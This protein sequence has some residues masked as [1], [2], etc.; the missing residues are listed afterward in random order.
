MGSTGNHHR[1]NGRRRHRPLLEILDDRCLLS[2]SAGTGLADHFAAHAIVGRQAT[3]RHAHDRAQERAKAGHKMGHHGAKLRELERPVGT[4]ETGAATAYDPIIGA[5][6]VRSTYGVQGTGMSVAVIDTGVD[7]N[8]PALGDGFGPNNKV[9]AGF[10]FGDGTANPMA[11]TSQ[12]GTSVAGLIGSDAPSDLGVA[13][14]VNIVALKVTDNSNTASLASVANALQWVINNHSAYNITSINMSLSDGGNY[15]ANWFANDGGDGQHV[16]QLIG[17]LSAMNIPVIAATGNSFAGQQGEGFAA[18]VAG[19][20]SVTATDLSGNLLSNAQRLGS[21]IGG[22]SATTIAAPGQGLTAPTGDSGTSTVEG[23]SFAT[24]LVTGGVT[25]LQ[26]IY[27]S[28]FGTLPTVTEI[29]DWLQ[30]SATRVYDPATG[31]TVGELN[32]SAAAAL[33][34]AAS[35]GAKPLAPAPPI[36][37]TSPPPVT[38]TSTA[39]ST[40]AS[41]STTTTSQSST[42]Q[43]S[44]SQTSTSSTATN[45]ASTS[46][47]SAA[48]TTTTSSTSTA[49]SPPPASV[50]ST[51]SVL[52][53]INGQ[54][55]NSAAAT[56]S[57]ATSSIN[58][59]AVEALFASLGVDSHSSGSSGPATSQLQIW[60]A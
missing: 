45:T 54:P 41:G 37:T 19:T 60:N 39:T 24:A 38:V 56:Q 59:S 47:S 14:G 57:D 32:L 29:K 18:I 30:Q 8:N 7:Y 20:I 34:P 25:L 52:V 51:A 5:S 42:S 23:T 26:Q 43:T 6:S 12:H 3:V 35:S 11:T 27:Q 46:T 1:R 40:P 55:V 4:V 10:D 17:Q 16:T 48:S 58:L 49:S 44:T 9:I 33:I 50:T 15:A 13:P 28:R 36:S 21:A 2:T 22:A 53:Y 31:I